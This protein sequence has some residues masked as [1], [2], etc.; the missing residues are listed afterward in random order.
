MRA[1]LQ[2]PRTGQLSGSK[3]Q[4]PGERQRGLQ[5]C[6]RQASEAMN[7]LVAFTETMASQKIL[8]VKTYQFI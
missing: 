4:R 5:G 6:T 3:V 1:N 8:C 7:T 2:C